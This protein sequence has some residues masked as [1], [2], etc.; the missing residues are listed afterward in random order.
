[1]WPAASGAGDTRVLSRQGGS[2]GTRAGTVR[3]PECGRLHAQ[4]PM[5]WACVLTAPARWGGRVPPGH[6]MYTPRAQGA[7]STHHSAQGEQAARQSHPRPLASPAHPR[8]RGGE[9]PSQ[10]ASSHAAEDSTLSCR[11]LGLSCP[12]WGHTGLRVPGRARSF[13]GPEAQAS[14]RTA[15]AQQRL[16]LGTGRQ[17]LE[18]GFVLAALQPSVTA[19]APAAPGAGHG[20]L[21]G[22]GRRRSRANGAEGYRSRSGRRR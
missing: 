3:F 13:P 22:G 17:G 21:G 18:L 20:G 8:S 10:P 5:C 16:D 12:G 1:M 11:A 7:P 2:W 19:E 14:G 4:P 9:G 6:S 15:G